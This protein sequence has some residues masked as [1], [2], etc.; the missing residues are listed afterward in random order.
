MERQPNT[1][2]RPSPSSSPTA[3]PTDRCRLGPCP[4]ATVARP[5]PP[6]ARP[7]ISTT[8]ASLPDGTF[9]PRLSR[10][11]HGG[12]AR[13][14]S[15]GRDRYQIYCAP[16]HGALGD[17]NGIT[18][19]Y[20]MGATPTYHDD[21][22][23]GMADGEIFNTITHGKNTCSPMPTS[24]PPMT[25]GRWSPTS[26]RPPTRQFGTAADVIDPA[27]QSKSR[28]QMSTHAAS[29]PAGLTAESTSAHAPRP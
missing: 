3:A 26:P 2:R 16:C 8:T 29:I 10:C 19:S 5:T 28:H 9:A 7:T 14:S 15:T 18:K 1:S 25:A 21:R 12:P 13:L 6:C 20:G 11:P 23:R 17:G 22:L 4:S 27:G 24:Y